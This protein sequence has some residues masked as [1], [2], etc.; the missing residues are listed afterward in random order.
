[1]DEPIAD[2]RGST[3]DAGVD[4][5]CDREV[6]VS[7]TPTHRAQIAA[8]VESTAGPAF[9]T[10]AITEATAL[11]GIGNRPGA[12]QMNSGY[13]WPYGRRENVL[14]GWAAARLAS[15]GRPFPRVVFRVRPSEGFASDAPLPT[16]EL[17]DT[18]DD[19]FCL[20][21]HA[22]LSQ[23]DGL[24]ATSCASR[25]TGDKGRYLADADVLAVY[26][27]PFEV[28]PAIGSFREL[29]L[30]SAYPPRRDLVAPVGDHPDVARFAGDALG[31]MPELDAVTRPTPPG[32]TPLVWAWRV[33]D[34][35]PP[36]RAAVTL[37]INTEGDYSGVHDP[38]TF[39]TPTTPGGAWDWWAQTYGYPFRGQPSVQFDV[40]IEV[41]PRDRGVPPSVATSTRPARM[42]TLDASL[43]TLPVDATIVDDPAHA[44]GSGADRLRLSGGT[45]LTVTARQ[46]CR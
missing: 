34:D 41:P 32:D 20:S 35:W 14:P 24:D 28:A 10:I 39:P 45:R 46:R 9:A 16:D 22:E 15:G 37:E 44:P 27:E 30:T 18:P 19:Y 43:R 31:A 21:F 4:L 26:A 3:E 2:G 17:R 12:F 13:R 25:F 29:G 8:W 42:G 23:R 38:S 1:M 36:G 7:F 40:A 33:P 6:L 5:V 11:R